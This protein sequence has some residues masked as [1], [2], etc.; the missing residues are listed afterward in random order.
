MNFIN[1]K[2]D[3]DALELRRI[4]R[5]DSQ[6]NI[7]MGRRMWCRTPHSNSWSVEFRTWG[8]MSRKEQRDTNQ[9]LLGK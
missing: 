6:G 2:F 5:G 4:H 7:P 3:L 8:S 9:K 1:V